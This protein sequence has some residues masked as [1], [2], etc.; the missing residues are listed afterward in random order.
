MGFQIV[1]F[2]KKV[3]LK[4][5]EDVNTFIKMCKYQMRKKY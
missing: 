5:E 2:F 4:D 1:I 3:L